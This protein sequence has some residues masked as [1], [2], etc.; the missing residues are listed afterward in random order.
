MAIQTKKEDEER[1]K[2]R[3]EAE[4]LAETPESQ[5]R[6]KD[7]KLFIKEREKQA[8]RLG[9]TPK[10]AMEL[11]SEREQQAFEQNV[12][13]ELEKEEARFLVEQEV[14]KRKQAREEEL[15]AEVPEEVETEDKRG[16]LETIVKPIDREDVVSNVVPF[17]IGGVGAPGVVPN[18]PGVP[19]LEGLSIPVAKETIAV[20][21]AKTSVATSVKA[22]STGFLIKAAETGGALLVGLFGLN[23]IVNL[24]E[25]RIKSISGEL[26]QIRETITAPVQAV[27]NG[28][29]SPDEAQDVLSDLESSMDEY[30]KAILA[31]RARSYKNRLKTSD[32]SRVLVRIRK[33]R[34]FI[35][36]AQQDV[37]LAKVTGQAPDAESIALL[38]NQLNRL[39]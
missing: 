23:T 20:N 21:A 14:E 25:N 4:K 38:A 33:L 24:P 16:L 39:K 1:R 27:R 10:R 7:A 28:A 32:S 31:E 36:V 11:A 29:M 37:A 19:P 26:E 5:Q 15:Q 2:K 9:L 3:E 8:T 6:K 22:K 17:P 13:P 12:R 30:E 35:D 34:F 18:V